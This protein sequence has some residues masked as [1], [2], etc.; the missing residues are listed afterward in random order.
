MSFEE[1]VVNFMLQISEILEKADNGM[2]YSYEELIKKIHM[3]GTSVEIIKAINILIIKKEI[4]IDIKSIPG[5]QLI[6][7]ICASREH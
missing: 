4:E 2:S 5:G 7:T 1:Q 6:F 3:S